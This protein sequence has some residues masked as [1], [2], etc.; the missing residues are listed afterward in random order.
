MKKNCCT[1]PK[2]NGA[3]HKSQLSRLN[4]IKGQL[5]GISRMIEEQSYCPD[6]ITQVQAIR[7]ALGS[8]QAT[9]LSAHLKDCIVNGIRSGEDTE[10]LTEEL[11]GI[12]KHI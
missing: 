9:L 12:F 4:R 3:D 10:K 1:S 7:S 2:K 8:L 5:E 6:I 11:L